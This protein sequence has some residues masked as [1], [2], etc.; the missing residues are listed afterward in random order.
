MKTFKHFIGEMGFET[1]INSSKSREDDWEFYSSD[2]GKKF[3]NLIY[4]NIGKDR[5]KIYLNKTSHISNYFLVLENKYKGHIS[6]NKN[7]IFESNSEIKSGFYKLMF[8]FILEHKKENIYSDTQMSTQ[9]IKSWAKL[10]QDKYNRLEIMIDSFGSLIQATKENYLKDTLSRFVVVY[11]TTNI[12]E[13]YKRIKDFEHEPLKIDENYFKNGI[14]EWR[15]MKLEMK[16]RNNNID[17]FL[18]SEEIEV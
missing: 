4:K 1:G 3:I 10:S 7:K 6:L 11:S 5:F 8:L 16:K 17:L 15:T 2:K 9:A 13:Y 12:S 14:N 18:F